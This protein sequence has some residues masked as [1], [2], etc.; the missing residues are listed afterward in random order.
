MPIVVTHV[1]PG[2]LSEG[3]ARGALWLHRALK[4]HCPEIDSR[5]VC[6]R[7]AE[8]GTRRLNPARRAESFLKAKLDSIRDRIACRGNYDPSRPF[9]SSVLAI[10]PAC[11]PDED[12]DL[13]HLH[14]CGRGMAG[15]TTLERLDLPTVLTVRDMWP[16]TGGCHYSLECTSYTDRCGRCPALSSDSPDDLSSRLL[17]RKAVAMRRVSRLVAISPWLASLMRSS[18]S[19]SQVPISVIP[20]A[21]DTDVF[22]PPTTASRAQQR[23]ILGLG[24]DE[25]AVLFGAQDFRDRYKG[26]ALLLEAIRLL[27]NNT[28]RPVVFG[29]ATE[30]I[31][32]HLG[33][34]CI[35]LGFIANDHRLADIYGACDLFVLPSLQE[36]FG[37]VVI[38]SQACGTPVVAF[39]GHGPDA[40][41]VDGSTG[42]LA[43]ERTANSLAETI[44]RAL[45]HCGAPGIRD[46]CSNSVRTNFGLDTMA[47]A[48]A[49]LYVELLA[50]RR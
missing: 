3:A 16:L 21:V 2:S 9:K 8:D 45:A 42:W 44:S 5:L 30:S 37:K 18:P 25:I 50:A 6:H 17:A 23:G 41:I 14:W 32:K 28:L 19:T 35:D 12:C 49:K 47:R 26:T 36:A 20:N 10:D 40:T 43:A 11:L 27:P 31:R 1:V 4:R 22:K 38:E 15:I 48:Y 7:D 46:A 13:L 34:Q 39:G 29:R 24:Q 33:P